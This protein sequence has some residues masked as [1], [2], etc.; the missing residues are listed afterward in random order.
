MPVA[1]SRLPV[2]ETAH[3]V[4]RVR[5]RPGTSNSRLRPTRSRPA[6]S[7][8]AVTGVAALTAAMLLVSACGGDDQTLT[9]PDGSLIST[10]TTRLAEVNIVGA[11]RDYAK[12]CFAPTAPDPGKQD[13]NR[14]VVTDPLL[15]DDLCALGVG[16][17][18][19]G[20]T[21]ADGDVPRYL[22][23]Q[24]ASVPTIGESPDAAAVG[25]ADPDIV[26]TT[27]DTSARAA[28]FAGTRVVTV[29]P[30][31]DPAANW[32]DRYLSVASALNRTTAA[33]DLLARF[34]REATRTGTRKD[35]VHTEVSLVRFAADGQTMEGTDSFAAQ[36]LAAIGVQRPVSQRRPGSTG[37]T[38][39]NLTD[40]DADLIYVSYRDA[41]DVTGPDVKGSTAFGHARSILESDRWLDMGAP[42]WKRV[43]AVDDTVWYSTSGLAAA[44]L[45]LNDVKGSL[46]S[47][48]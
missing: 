19:T 11:D 33:T 20:I 12:T 21:V 22:G 7:T 48:S 47:A 5:C 6:L 23:P 3:Y 16:A 42:T 14:I 37:L 46:D 2:S 41:G 38:D 25:T 8:R 18:V 17:K 36:V 32:A 26:L 9:T 24:L 44:W 34:T 45:V 1:A 30:T 27:P 29:D 43:L 39:D 15:L 13:V 4:G 40:A 35:A 28:G 10:P 31:A